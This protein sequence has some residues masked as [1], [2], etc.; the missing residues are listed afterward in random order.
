MICYYCKKD[1]ECTLDNFCLS[2]CGKKEYLC[3]YCTA[4]IRMSNVQKKHEKDGVHSSVD[5][6]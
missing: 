2:Y 5:L 4:R 6:L 1:L 3:A